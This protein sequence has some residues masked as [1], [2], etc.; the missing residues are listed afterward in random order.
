MK[1][2]SPV[3]SR[4][5]PFQL[6]RGGKG[7]YHPSCNQSLSKKN[8]NTTL[9]PVRS[10]PRSSSRLQTL[11]P[12]TQQLFEQR[13]Q[14]FAATD[15]QPVFAESW[16]STECGLSPSSATTSSD[17]ETPKPQ[18]ARAG[19]PADSSEPGVQQ[20]SVLAKYIDRFRHGQPQSRQ[21][22]Q[23]S[24]SADGEKQ[25]PFWW[26][27]PSS[28][29]CSSTPTKTTDKDSIQPLKE[30]HGLAIF[31]PAG[32]HR[33]DRS[34]SPCRGSLSVSAFMLSDI[35]HGEFDDTDI[36]HL[37]EKAGRL[38]LRGEC[39]PSDGS[40]PVSS[41]GLECSDFSSP[42]S[43]YEPVRRPLIPSSSVV[44]PLAPPT[45]RE[46][47]ILFQW[48][49]RR[50]MEQ[51]REGSQSL[52]HSSL[53]GPTFS[54]QA[55]SSSH[56]S[57][58]GQA[59]KQHQ[60]TQPPEFSQKST[61]PHIPAHRPQ[62][63]EAHG[64]CPQA[65]DPTPFPAF[66]VSGSSISQPQ[67]IAHVPAHMH[68]LCDVLP[69]PIQSSR[70]STHQHLSE[71][72]DE[73]QTKVVCEKTQVP[74]NSMNTFTDGRSRERMPSPPASS[75][76]IGRAELIRHKRSERN[77][78]EKN[79]KKTAPSFRKQKKSTRYTVDREHDDGPGPTNRNFSHQNIP[80][81]VL[82]WAEQRQ[83]EGSQGFSSESST[84]DQAPPPSPIHSALGQVVSEV[85]FP[86]VD[87]SPTQRTPVTSVS[88]PCTASPPPQSSVPPCNAQN[89]MEVISQ[90][91][92]EAEDSDEKEFEDD[93]LLQVLRKQR[94]WVKEQISEVDSILN[95]FLDEQQVTSPFTRGT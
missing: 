45:R 85:L 8:N 70:A 6:S 1:S 73:S 79:E 88:P 27:S 59:Y 60:I 40:I 29:P 2:S 69:C 90:L 24:P 39:S 82:P 9:S 4:Q 20:D 53:H 92:Q 23:Q 78:K 31:S 63:K 87:P 48:R 56:P 10:N 71:S 95:E 49:L 50:K 46:E 15:G 17:M 62:T 11:C 52:Q 43:V 14:R 36:Q 75:G 19:K 35:S 74:G 34:L 13:Q 30:D 22:R 7:Y 47:D 80:K 38:L 61:R 91:L 93:P 64:S 41:E 18:S 21:E 51:A 65:S 44:P 3:F 25:Q 37:Q 28:L 94:K 57:A 68:L 84:G 32:Q 76:A 16:P 66:V 12:E 83:Q 55:P 67:A 26:I 54:W 5:N 72:I 86:S 58:S 81:I 77:K 33:H 89:S 42:V